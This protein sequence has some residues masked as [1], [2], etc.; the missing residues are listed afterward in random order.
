MVFSSLAVGMLIAW[1][2]V[3]A[4]ELVVLLLFL[5]HFPT[6]IA[7]YIIYYGARDHSCTEILVE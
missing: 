2:S 1:G 4:G 3:D 5:L 6:V 7:V